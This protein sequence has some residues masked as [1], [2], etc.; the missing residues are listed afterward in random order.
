M[1]GKEPDPAVVETVQAG[2]Q[3]LRRLDRTVLLAHRNE[4][5]SY[6]E[7]AVMTGLTVDQVEH[8]M[9]RALFELD[10]YRSGY[11]PPWWHR[12]LR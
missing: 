5:M 3:T 11:R 2:L 4:A 1:S 7:I 6:P 10:R 12:W 8:R 9:A